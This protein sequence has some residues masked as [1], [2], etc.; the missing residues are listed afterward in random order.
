AGDGDAGN[1]TLNVANT[2]LADDSRINSNI[3]IGNRED[4]P[5]LGKV[6]NIIINAENMAFSNT[7]QI[8][9]G[10]F[11]GATV[12]QP[13]I[14]SLTATESISFTGERTGIFGNNERGSLGDASDIR[15]SAP[16]ITLNDNAGITAD[17]AGNGQG[18]DIIIDTEQ[19]TLHNSEILA[20]ISGEGNAGSVTV[21]S[22]DSV[23]L[24]EDSSI[25]A[26]IQNN[27]IGEGGDI[28]IDT[29]TLTLSEASF[30]T[31]ELL[32]NAIGEGGDITVDTA[33]L[34]L[35]RG[36]LISA[37]LEE[38]ATGEGGDITIDTTTLTISEGSLISAVTSGE[39]DAG[40]ITVNASETVSLE[41][42]WIDN[43]SG[44]ISANVEQGGIGTA[45]DIELTTANLSI[46]NG[47]NVSSSVFGDGDAGNITINAR[48]TVSIEGVGTNNRPSGVFTTV[49]QGGIGNAGELQLITANLSLTDGGAVSSS[50]SGQGDAGDI[51]INV[52]DSLTLADSGSITTS[53]EPEAIGD[54]GNITIGVFQQQE[55]D[56]V[57]DETQFT[58]EITLADEGLISADSFGE[59][60]GGSITVR[61]GNVDLNQG[62]ISATTQA[63]ISLEERDNT[64]LSE[65]DLFV[66]ENLTLRDNSNISARANNDANGG[67]I[68][69]GAEFIIAYP[70]GGDGND[71]TASAE[72][73]QGG[74]ISITAESL[75]GIEERRAFD[76]NGTNDI[77][78]SSGTDGLDGTVTIETPDNNPLRETPELTDNVV[79]AEVIT[80]SDVC[81]ASNIEDV[82]SLA[83]QGKGGIAPEPTAPFD[84]DAL[85]VNGESETSDVPQN[86]SNNPKPHEI[87]PHI[88][89]VAYKDNGEPIYIARGVMKQEDGTVI[90]TAV[91]HQNISPRT[92]E[93]PY[94]C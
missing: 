20:N 74:A 87:P 34:T 35:S 26:L 50:T 51:F 36:S 46:S 88:Q 31:V 55:N 89:P 33:T 68:N 85:I 17:N 48:E 75:L 23:L 11:S 7:A 19:L 28:T 69:I 32:E 9:A 92:P 45:G 86:S 91:P 42:V 84:G 38:N 41:G 81:S 52:S 15:L 25:Q 56:L 62:Q 60:I 12:E 49:E 30:I 16:T 73:G 61:G 53:V 14:I 27:A 77:D 83:V 93:N 70:S 3:G 80:T 79:T 43:V 24:T 58:S 57:L 8:Q 76:N 47:G 67:N 18:G 90:L 82:S 54:G 6:G 4:A 44:G 2:F 40:D 94:S 29:A 72:Q 64:S 66:D 78:A 21:N 13:G 65:I 22:T 59:G 39:G 37:E 63:T 71:I 5:A 1:I 10:A